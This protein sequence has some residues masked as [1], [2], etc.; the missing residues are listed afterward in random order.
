MGANGFGFVLVA[1]AVRLWRWGRPAWGGC[2]GGGGVG[3]SSG[4]V[5]ISPFT[6]GIR[7]GVVRPVCVGRRGRHTLPHLC[8]C[9][10][11]PK[12]GIEL[13]A[14]KRSRL[15]SSSRPSSSQS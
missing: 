9:E 12:L 15:T 11:L 2:R 8:V 1:A 3:R 14:M 13:E 7:T 6:R 4:T 5:E 10:V